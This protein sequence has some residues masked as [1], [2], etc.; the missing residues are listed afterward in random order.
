MRRRELN[1]R[2]T[3]E[4]DDIR[5][6]QQIVQRLALVLGV[7]VD[8]RDPFVHLACTAAQHRRMP[9]SPAQSPLPPSEI[10]LEDLS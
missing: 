7:P 6:S 10:G 4:A 1:E 5:V 8:D 3:I 9:I 2:T